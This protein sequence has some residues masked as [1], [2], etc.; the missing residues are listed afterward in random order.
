MTLAWHADDMKMSH[1]DPEEVTKFMEKLKEKFE[2][3]FGIVK[4]KRGKRHDTRFH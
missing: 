3:E 2:D 1:V 4:V